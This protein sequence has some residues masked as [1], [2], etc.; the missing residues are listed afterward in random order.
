M[1]QS[2]LL[3][4][5]SGQKAADMSSSFVTLVTTILQASNP[6]A[7]ICIYVQLVLVLTADPAH[8]SEIFGHRSTTIGG[9]KC[10]QDLLI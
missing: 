10:L 2:S 6:K 5:V 7:V 3:F 9:M 8:S 4:R 1:L